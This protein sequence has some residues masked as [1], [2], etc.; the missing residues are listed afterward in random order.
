MMLNISKDSII[1]DLFSL[2]EILIYRI[3]FFFQIFRQI[4]LP[5]ISPND[6]LSTNDWTT[7]D[8]IWPL[9]ISSSAV[10]KTG[11][12]I[13]ADKVYSHHQ[14]SYI[15]QIHPWVPT[16]A[17]VSPTGKHNLRYNKMTMRIHTSFIIPIWWCDF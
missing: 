7:S 10:W 1:E 14:K 9:V 16:Q 8:N 6:I 13:L 15:F 12:L 11:A 17:Y 3:Y 2:S 4:S 5:S